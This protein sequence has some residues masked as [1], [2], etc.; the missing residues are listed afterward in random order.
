MTYQRERETVVTAEERPP[1]SGLGTIVAIVVLLLLI[2]AA[3]WF[4]GLAGN[5][6]GGAPGGGATTAPS[7]QESVPAESTMPSLEASPS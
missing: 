1:R 2:L 4:F 7:G 5:Q 6:G 3:I